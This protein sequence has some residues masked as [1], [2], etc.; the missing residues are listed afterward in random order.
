MHKKIIFYGGVQGSGK[1]EILQKVVEKYVN[2]K[3]LF[4]EVRISEL[5]AEQIR[6][7]SRQSDKSKPILWGEIN[8]KRYDEEVVEK[9]IGKI[10]VRNKT[11]VLNGHFSIPF[12][13]KKI[14]CPGWRC[15]VWK[16]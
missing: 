7:D 14:I 8:W 5:F 10:C 16:S 13:E 9:L 3:S 12:R 4:E 6:S 11:F 15:P 2:Y 1:T